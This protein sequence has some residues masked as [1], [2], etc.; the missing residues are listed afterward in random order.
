MRSCYGMFR[1]LSF[2]HLEFRVHSKDSLRLRLRTSRP[3]PP[4]PAQEGVAAERCARVF[5]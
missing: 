4:T 2:S 5:L 1:F 3:T